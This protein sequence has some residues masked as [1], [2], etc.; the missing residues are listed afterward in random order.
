VS[1]DTYD[2]YFLVM[3]RFVIQVDIGGHLPIPTG[4]SCQFFST[5]CSS[6][7]LCNCGF[8]TSGDL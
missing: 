8:Y 3:A 4:S 7:L 5:T 6:V 1:I 2:L